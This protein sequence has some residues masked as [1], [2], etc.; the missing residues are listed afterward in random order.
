MN[1]SCPLPWSHLYIDY[2]GE[3]GTCC[4]SEFRNAI[5]ISDLASGT[6]KL[7]DLN[8]NVKKQM[9][10]S[11]IPKECHH[12]SKIEEYLIESP[13]NYYNSLKGSV[14]T[15]Q[16]D[17]QNKVRTLDLRFGNKCNL[18]CRMCNPIS[19]KL[20]LNDY[21]QYLNDPN[22][23]KKSENLDWYKDIENIEYLVSLSSDLTSIYFSGGEPLLIKEHWDFLDEVISSNNS[24]EIELVY[25]TNLNFNLPIDQMEKWTNFKSVKLLPS[26]DGVGEVYNFI[27][28]PGKFDNFD[29][30]LNYM[31]KE[32]SNSNINRISV[33]FT[34]QN[35]NIL[36]LENVFEYLFK[37]K[38]SQ[39]GSKG[40]L[41]F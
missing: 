28:F 31:D 12:C 6:K 40:V 7:E 13:R 39:V 17:T 36:N 8:L 20:L 19:S 33:V 26:M 32:M 30:N 38:L 22:Y 9:L 29:E 41:S 34:L 2:F 1:F 24:K 11:S 23:S 15:D 35:L 3:V 14:Y 25:S 16:F 37:F 5:S 21:R 18:A 4:F 27:R 10:N